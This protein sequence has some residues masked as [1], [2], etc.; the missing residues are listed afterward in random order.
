MRTD[1]DCLSEEPGFNS[2]GRPVDFVFGFRGAC[3]EIN[4]SD[5]E[6]GFDGVLYYLRPFANIELSDAQ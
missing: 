3:F 5:R 1:R 6:R 2:P 4:F